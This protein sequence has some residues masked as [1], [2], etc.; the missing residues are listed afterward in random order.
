LADHIVLGLLLFGR[1]LVAF[2]VLVGGRTPLRLLKL[3]L[4]HQLEK[5]ASLSIRPRR[6]AAL[7]CSSGHRA[8]LRYATLGND[9][10]SAS[11]RMNMAGLLD[12]PMRRIRITQATKPGYPPVISRVSKELC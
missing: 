2:P 7:L 1:Q 11:F 12:E 4:L 6:A 9:H 10:G 3:S 8:L 5:A